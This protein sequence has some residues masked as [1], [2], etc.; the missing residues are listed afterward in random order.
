MKTPQIL[1]SCA[2]VGAVAT[3]ALLNTGTVSHTNF[4]G[5]EFTEAEREFINF[6]ANHHRSYGTKEE[7][8]FRLSLFA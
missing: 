4:M 3:F 5:T 2:V 6:I 8:N 1:A 7:Y